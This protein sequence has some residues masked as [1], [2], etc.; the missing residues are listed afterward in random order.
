MRKRIIV[1]IFVVVLLVIIGAFLGLYG[2]N[3][4]GDAKAERQNAIFTDGGK[5]VTSTVSNTT[6]IFHIIFAT[7]IVDV[8][9]EQLSKGINLAN[10]INAFNVSYPFQINLSNNQLVVSAKIENANGAIIAEIANNNEWQIINPNLKWDRNYNTYA[11][12]VLADVSKNSIPNVIPVLQVIMENQT[13]VLIGCYMDTP[14]GQVVATINGGITTYSPTAIINS[15][16]VQTI[17]KYPSKDNPGVLLNPNYVNHYSIF[18]NSTNSTE[19]LNQNII[20]PRGNPVSEA[21][22][23]ILFGELIAIVG[24]ILVAI[25]SIFG[26]IWIYQDEKSKKIAK[27]AFPDFYNH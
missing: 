8:S 25:V 2:N 6:D 16:A 5:I 27:S 23:Q 14:K 22:L 21:D 12:E 10:Y 4:Y 20:F 3:L 24:V 15:T 19:N 17:F 1:R 26:T 11:F 18:E 13:T 9:R 7:N